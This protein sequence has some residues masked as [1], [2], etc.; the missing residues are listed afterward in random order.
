MG[1]EADIPE[2]YESLLRDALGGDYSDSVSEG[3]LEASWRVWTPLLRKL[4]GGEG[5]GVEVREYAYGMF[6][7]L[8]FFFYVSIYWRCNWVVGLAGLRWANAE[9]MLGSEG[10]EGLEEFVKRYQYQREGE[11]GEVI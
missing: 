4:E 8:P 10:P 1:E 6:F 7:L 5:E 3:E 11:V 2:A 9:M